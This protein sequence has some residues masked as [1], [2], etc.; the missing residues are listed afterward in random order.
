M[1][2]RQMLMFGIRARVMVE[3]TFLSVSGGHSHDC[4]N[5]ASSTLIDCDTQSRAVTPGGIIALEIST[6]IW[7]CGLT[8]CWSARRC[9]RESCGPISTGKHE[10]VNRRLRITRHWLLISMKQDT[11]LIP[12]GRRRTLALQ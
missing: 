2:R 10:K 6:R 4:V 3:H 8:I 12:D 5:G 9:S 11:N 1:S 7:A